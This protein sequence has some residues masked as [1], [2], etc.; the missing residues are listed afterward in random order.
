MIAIRNPLE[1]ELL[2]SRHRLG[3]A[4]DYMTRKARKLLD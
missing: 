2:Q 4:H 3:A 1:R